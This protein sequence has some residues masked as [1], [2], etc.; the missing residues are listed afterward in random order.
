VLKICYYYAGSF[1]LLQLQKAL[2]RGRPIG[3]LERFMNEF[4]KGE[5]VLCTIRHLREKL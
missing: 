4:V 5:E 2:R 3:E 1:L